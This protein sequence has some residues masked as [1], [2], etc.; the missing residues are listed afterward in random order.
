M[1]KTIKIAMEAGAV[2]LALTACG[3]TE[4]A[5]GAKKD[6]EGLVIERIDDTDKAEE[7]QSSGLAD[8]DATESTKEE[9]PVSA[10]DDAPEKGDNTDLTENPKGEGQAA[11]DEQE[12]MQNRQGQTEESTDAGNSLY[13]AFLKNEI[14]VANPY[15]EGMNLTVM[16]DKN[17]ESEFEDAQ[18]KYAYVDV[19]ADDSPELIFKISSDTS[20]LMYILGIC[21]NELICFDV[22]ESHTRNISFGVY[23]Y[24]LVWEIQNYDG[25][26]MT[27]YSY[28]AD[29]QQM[30]AR[31]FTEGDE[32]DIA[33]HEGEEPEW[34]C[35]K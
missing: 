27:L 14:S 13:E 29:G 19:N 28:T 4:S 2:V 23:D 24:G 30:R 1:M 3:Q 6:A 9:Q 31:H 35:V 12:T 21:D 18:K 22:F 34:I 15:V 11:S 32:A 25:F 8:T 5:E 17:Y 26:E 20:D 33:A 10:E 16:D 7:T